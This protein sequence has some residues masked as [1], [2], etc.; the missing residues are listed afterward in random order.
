MAPRIDQLLG[1]VSSRYALVHAMSKRARQL[2]DYRHQANAG[3]IGEPGEGGD[4]FSSSPPPLIHSDSSNDLTI[5]MQEIAEG[6]LVVTEV[7]ARELDE[8]RLPAST[9]VQFGSDLDDDEE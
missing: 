8:H 9:S 1:K 7:E 2:N 6:K 5:A 3:M 4:L